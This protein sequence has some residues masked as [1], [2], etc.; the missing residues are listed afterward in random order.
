MTMFRVIV[1]LVT[2]FTFIVEG[3]GSPKA[4]ISPIEAADNPEKFKGQQISWQG[5]TTDEVRP[6]DTKLRI[7]VGSGYIVEARTNLPA[8]S[9]IGSGTELL[10]EGV[11]EGPGGTILTIR[12]GE[13]VGGGKTL[14]VDKAT[15]V[16]AKKGEE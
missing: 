8:T 4:S 3:C 14:V 10:V 15:A 7:K 16:P 6:G 9:R 11:Y 13:V 1:V 5:V 2:F 12:D